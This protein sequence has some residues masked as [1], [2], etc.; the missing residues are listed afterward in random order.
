M[1]SH[2][3]GYTCPDTNGAVI[4]TRIEPCSEVSAPY[5]NMWTLTKMYLLQRTSPEMHFIPYTG[6]RAQCLK[7]YICLL[8]LNF[9]GDGMGEIHG[10]GLASHVELTWLRMLWF[11]ILN[12]KFVTKV[13]AAETEISRACAIIEHYTF[14]MIFQWYKL[15]FRFIIISDTF[16]GHGERRSSL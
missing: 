14:S 3:P 10:S 15:F 11:P 6:F 13:C 8:F 5:G 9:C 4:R 12:R 16:S 1:W 2:Q 7:F